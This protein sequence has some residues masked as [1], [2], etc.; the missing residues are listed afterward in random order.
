MARHTVPCRENQRLKDSPSLWL[1]RTGVLILLAAATVAVYF[2]VS[3]FDFIDLDDPTYVT[4]NGFVKQGMTIQGVRWA[5]SSF[6]GA[7]WHPLT[8]ISHMIDVQFFGMNPGMHHLTSVFFHVLNTLLLFLILER[9]TGAIWKSA[10]VAALFALHPLH[11]ESV[12]WV[13]ERKDVL[14]TFFWMLTMAAYLW[15]VERRTVV[16]YLAV[17][18]SLILGLLSKPMLVTLPFVL[19]LLDF[20][21]LRRW[22]P[23]PSGETR[24]G[25]APNTPIPLNV[26][27]NPILLL[28]EKMPLILLSAASSSVT[29]LAQYAG[30]AVKDLESL[31]LA[32]RIAN[33]I[34][35]YARYLWMT[36]FP[37]DL[38]A[39]YPYQNDLGMIPVTLSAAFLL[40]M[41][42][43]A[44]R[45]AEKLPY[46][47]VGWLWYL[48]TLFPVVGIVQVGSQA[49]ADRYTYVPLIGIFMAIS[50]GLSDLFCRMHVRKTVLTAATVGVLAACAWSSWVQ[51]GLWK[52]SET[53]FRH[54]LSVTS[55]NYLVH[56]DLGYTLYRRGDVEGAIMHYQEALKIKPDLPQVHNNLGSILLIRGDIDG[57]IS[58]YREALRIAPHQ[59]RVYNNLGVAFMRRGQILIAIGY[60]KQAIQEDPGYDD[61]LVNLKNA[62]EKLGKE[63]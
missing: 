44:L 38:A 36:V 50:W 48:G 33:A 7:N 15:Y 19:L 4:S 9:M 11:V 1:L 24:S 12:A 23:Y 18:F 58:H 62:R 17:A 45:S 32:T 27:M 61:A 16:K 21:P 2:Q 56:Y 3:A 57:A 14:S 43:A 42:L 49:M 63:D 31:Q 41:T 30:G 10:A 20:W 8:W 35:S 46:L 25:N 6:H 29:I 60:F 53:L 34:V 5:F 47:A 22:N 59:P 51:A 40:F 54:A 13:S 52:N 37:H 39:Y 55:D 28:A 26:P